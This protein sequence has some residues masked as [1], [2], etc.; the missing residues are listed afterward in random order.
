MQQTSYQLSIKPLLAT[1]M[2]FVVLALFIKSQF[3]TISPVPATAPETVFSGERAFEMLQHLTKEQVPHIVD[4]PEN[5]VV[6]QRLVDLLSDMGYQSQIQDTQVCHTWRSRSATR[7]TRVRNV[8]VHIQGSQPGKG[9]LLSAH[10]DSGVSSPGASDAGSAVATLLETARLLSLGPQP[11]NSIVL[12]FNEGE[13]FGLMG[14]RAFMEQHP[15]AKTLQLAINIEARGSSGQSVM[16]ETGENSGWL[17]ELYAQTTPAPLSSSLFYEA[18]KFLPNDTDMTV[19]KKYGLQGLN[20]AHGERLPHYHTPMDNLQNLD[21]GSLQHHGD[22]VWGVLE[23]LKD[24]DLSK[25]K[26][27]NLVYTD[28]MGLFMI[29]WDEASSIIFSSL[30][31]AALV[32]LMWHFIRAQ[33]LNI[34][35]LAVGVLAFLLI[36]L[37]A[38]ACS[39]LIQLGVRQL[40][41]SIEPWYSNAIP[42]RLSLWLSA[43]V[44][45][46]FI[47]R[48]LSRNATS[49]DMAFAVTM[50]WVLLSCVTSWLMAGISFLFVIPG[51][52]G[53]IVL[54]CI[55]WLNQSNVADQVKGKWQTALLILMSAISVLSF[56]TMAYLLEV[57]LTYR[58]AVVIGAFVGLGAVTLLPL[59]AIKNTADAHFKRMSMAVTGLALGSIVWTG[60]QPSYSEWMPQH[61]NINYVQNEKNEAFVVVGNSLNVLPEQLLNE[62]A[63]TPELSRVFPWSRWAFY[64]KKAQPDLIQPTAIEFTDIS[65]NEGSKK[66]AI[67]IFSEDPDFQEFRVFI[68]KDAALVSIEMGKDVNEYSQRRKANGY[69]Q[70]RCRGLSCAQT[71]LIVSF[72]SAEPVNILIASVFRGVPLE[73]KTLTVKRGPEAVQYLGGDQSIIIKALHL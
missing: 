68:P 9:I 32:L 12:L 66:V 31:L 4:T 63:T 22:N 72:S 43:L 34:K 69:Y 10:Y 65:D 26:T 38:V 58:M 13:E 61:L 51:F 24:I 16:F 21:R 17:V 30:I 54:A 60:L 42:M 36:I 70:F 23:R 28:V 55:V 7:C 67:D 48:W 11:R 52:A 59:L 50:V 57:L 39:Y 44:S 49:I 2:V 8:I 18:Y 73:Y 19:F 71:K 64:N 40:S 47:G 41:D 25:A 33:T 37:A 5:R 56:I 46:L 3:A 27:G 35:Q 29:Q 14:A 1:L 20:F 62:L 45:V 15:L 6:E 53:V